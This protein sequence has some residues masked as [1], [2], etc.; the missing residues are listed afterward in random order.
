MKRM[1]ALGAVVWLVAAL[2]CARAQVHVS[3]GAGQK[4]SISLAGF[5]SGSS[6]AATAFRRTLESDLQRSGWFAV[7]PGSAE[8]AI[9]GSCEDSG[10]SLNVACRVFETATADRYLSKSYRAESAGARRLAHQVSDEI[11]YALTGRKGFASARLVVVGRKTGHKELYLCDSDGQGLVQLT[12]DNSISLAPKWSPDG[13]L[14]VYT[15]YLKRYP[16]VYAVEVGSGSRR[17]L[18]SFPGLNTCAEIAPNGR[19]VAVVL[20]K[21]GSPELY[22]GSLSGGSPV[23]ITRT[24]R[25][26]EA[27]PSWSPDGGQIVYVSDQSGTPQLYIT[28]RDGAA[29]R[30]LTSRG[31]E[32]VAPDWGSGGLIAFTTRVGGRYQ[33]CVVNPT[34]L[35]LRQITADDAD[36]EDPSWAPDGRHIACGRTRQHRSSIYLLDTMGDPPLALLDIP[37]D[38]FSPAWSSK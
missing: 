35:E 6:A 18:F 27:S 3:K 15:S 13:R 19:D 11:V 20:S 23:R 17:R 5:V 25:A 30:R 8:F 36:Y 31:S 7:V 1:L 21:D 38:W 22:A 33:V 37:G 28:T 32:N 2:P 10:A 26:A 16:D 12:R 34:T 24:P 9:Q 14:L 4:S 29:P